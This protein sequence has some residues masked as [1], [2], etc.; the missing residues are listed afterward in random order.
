MRIIS[1]NLGNPEPIRDKQGKVFSSAIQ[2][3]PCQEAIFLS[4]TGLK[5]DSSFE[6]CHGGEN[7]ALH[8]FCYENYTFFEEKAG[9]SL[10]IPAFGENI[11]ISAYSEK[12]ARVGD[13]LKIGSARIQVAQPT[14]RCATIGRS[15]GLPKMLKWIHE[16]LMTGFYLRVLEEGEIQQSNSI[17]LEERGEE[18]LSIAR[19]NDLIFAE[20]NRCELDRVCS[21]K[22]LNEEWKK[23]AYLLYDRVGM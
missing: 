4:K 6:D 19:L 21:S 15:L 11:T 22:I 18:S 17:Q 14:E 7:M 3:K 12:E 1:L 8:M 9:F 10:P 16:K 2:K 23:R 5:G 13:I 20:K